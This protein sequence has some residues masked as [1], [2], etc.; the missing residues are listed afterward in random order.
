MSHGSKTL[1]NTHIAR[2]RGEAHM[3]LATLQSVL[4]A[5]VKTEAK[6]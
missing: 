1:L 2:A 5:A 3:P 4:E 6:P